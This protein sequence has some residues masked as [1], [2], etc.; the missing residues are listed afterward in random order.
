[1]K[2]EI[3]LLVGII[4]FGLVS[5]SAL[6][7][8]AA[9]YCEEMNYTYSGE[10]CVFSDGASCD[11][12]AFYNG[13]CGQSYVKNVSCAVA[14]GREGIG[15]VCCEGFLPLENIVLNSSGDCHVLVGGYS[16]C[17]DCG[18][19]VCDSWENKCNCELDCGV[20]REDAK[21]CDDGSVLE[22]DP[23]LGCEF[24]ACS[25]ES[26]AGTCKDLCGDG[27]CQKIVCQGSECPC[28]ENSES[29]AIDC[30]GMSVEKW[31]LKSLLGSFHWSLSLIIVA[32]ICAFIG[33]KIL[34]WIFWS[35]AVLAAVLAILFFVF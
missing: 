18:D 5:V 2:R 21:I 15:V 29:C 17:S 19:G 1:M 16:I 13:T 26:S 25:G 28:A 30:S 27:E 7:N 9:S 11:A 20:C 33:F 4:L 23:A 14:G 10:S 6:P 31:G 8:P 12:W 34:K 32:V 22:R 24:P 35:L 3:V